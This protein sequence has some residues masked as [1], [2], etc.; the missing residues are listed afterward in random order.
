MRVLQC[1]GG[2]RY[3]CD[4]YYFCLTNVEESEVGALKQPCSGTVGANGLVGFFLSSK[5]VS[6]TDP[7]RRELP[8]QLRRLRHKE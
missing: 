8:V 7:R 5:G 4:Y 2:V 6:E 1:G 3:V